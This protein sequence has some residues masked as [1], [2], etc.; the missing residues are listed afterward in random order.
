MQGGAGTFNYRLFMTE[1]GK[2]GSFWHDV[3]LDNGDG[4]VNFVC[5]IPKETRAKMEVATVSP[6]CACTLGNSRGK[7]PHLL[8][9]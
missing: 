9:C 6:A 5:E 2:V 3:P 7:G 1:G 4:S 8:F